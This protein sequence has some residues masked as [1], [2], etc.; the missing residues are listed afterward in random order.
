MNTKWLEVAAGSALGREHRRTDRPN[1]DAFAIRRSAGAVAAAVCDGCGSGAHSEL[2]ARL[3]ANLLAASALA[4]VAPLADLADEVAWRGVCDEVL[5][6]LE[7]V[8]AALAASDDA[9]ARRAAVAEH[10]LF[11][12][13]VAVVTPAGAAVLAVGDGVVVLDGAV[14]VLGDGDDAPGYLGYELCGG[15]VERAVIAAPGADTLVLATDGARGLLDHAGAPLP[16]GRGPVLDL[17]AL[18]GEPRV[19]RNPDALRRRLAVASAGDGGVLHDDTTVVALRRAREA[20]P[21]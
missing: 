11:T 13:L 6:R 3:G 15:T 12:A 21:C 17:A 16:G 7:P 5:A 20:A 10:L 2:G 4:R 8:V 19:W 18:A 1:Q 14:T 9:A